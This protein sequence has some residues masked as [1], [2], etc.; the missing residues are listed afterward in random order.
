MFIF[1]MSL[2]VVGSGMSL[3]T[4]MQLVRDLQNAWIMLDHVKH[5][6]RWTCMV[7]HVYNSA[8]C[9][10]MTIAIC[11]MHFKDAEVQQVMWTKLNDTMLKHMFLKLNFKGFMVDNAQANWNTIII[12]YGSG[13]P[14]MKMVDKECKCLFH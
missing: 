5:V 4:R 3:V 7:C 12:V 6:V 11:D 10:L 13:D 8:Y 14:F 1:K 2:N 9:K